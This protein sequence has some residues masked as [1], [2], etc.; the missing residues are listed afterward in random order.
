M[1][2]SGGGD[3]YPLARIRDMEKASASE[4]DTG[5]N[6]SGNTET[7]RKLDKRAAMVN[8]AQ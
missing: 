1:L 7:V 8:S 2:F 3:Y 6:N 5:A 4:Y